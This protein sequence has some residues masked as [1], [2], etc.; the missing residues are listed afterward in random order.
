MAAEPTRDKL[1]HSA[2]ELLVEEGLSGVSM[3]RVATGSGVSATAIYRHFEDKDALL[4]A[5]VVESFRLFGSYLLDALEQPTPEKRLRQMGQRYFDFALEHRH[6]YQLIFMTNCAD[7]GL[8]RL[9]ETGKREIS[10]TFQMLQDRIVE[11]Q[12]AGVVKKGDPRSLSAWVWSS[13]HGL[14]ALIITGNLDVGEKENAV[15]I[16]QQ[17]DLIDRSLAVR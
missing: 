10:G 11:C 8:S 4:A 9:D 6:D 15:L 16:E 13:I 14:A 1:L 2:R 5:A 7:L 17:L 3:R 12:K